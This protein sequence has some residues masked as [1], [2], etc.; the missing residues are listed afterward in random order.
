MA[1]GIPPLKF[2]PPAYNLK[3]T[4]VER[5]CSV[6]FRVN[7]VSGKEQDNKFTF[8]VLGGPSWQTITRGG[9]MPIPITAPLGK[10]SVTVEVTEPGSQSVVTTRKIKIVDSRV[11]YASLA[12]FIDKTKVERGPLPQAAYATLFGHADPKFS[13][14]IESLVD[15]TVDG[16]KW[17]GVPASLPSPYKMPTITSISTAGI[18]FDPEYWARISAGW[19][20]TNGVTRQ[21]LTCH[22]LWCDPVSPVVSMGPIGN[23]TDA[24]I[25]ASPKII[26]YVVGVMGVSGSPNPYVYLFLTAFGSLRPDMRKTKLDNGSLWNDVYQIVSRSICEITGLTPYGSIGPDDF[27][28]HWAANLFFLDTSTF[29]QVQTR[30][31]Q[32]SFGELG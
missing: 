15:L 9:A 17:L 27:F 7:R 13:K 25:A 10:H 14:E 6:S 29:A 20:P 32:N 3:V 22:Q 19:T 23:P 2:L 12:D 4:L 28:G 8:R 31:A 26:P 16:K 30:V 5:G 11:R 18:K 24:I 1:L 21:P